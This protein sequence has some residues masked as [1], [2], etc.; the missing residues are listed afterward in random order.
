MTPSDPMPQQVTLSPNISRRPVKT[1]LDI[2]PLK[3]FDSTTLA[4]LQQAKSEL[5]TNKKRIQMQKGQC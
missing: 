2:L 4:F 1:K 5:Y 3:T